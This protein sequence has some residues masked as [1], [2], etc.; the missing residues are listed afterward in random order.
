MD[1]DFLSCVLTSPHFCAHMG[2]CC[3]IVKCDL[4]CVSMDTFHRTKVAL[5]PPLPLSR[6]GR[7]MRCWAHRIQRHVYRQTHELITSV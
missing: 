4:C 1:A 7:Q 5:T 6:T 3:F 2:P